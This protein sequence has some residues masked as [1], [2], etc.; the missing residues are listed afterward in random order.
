[1]GK[2]G[3]INEGATGGEGLYIRYGIEQTYLERVSM[4]KVVESCSKDIFLGGGISVRTDEED[5][6]VLVNR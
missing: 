1:V 3:I 6:K 5:E 2:I 4:M